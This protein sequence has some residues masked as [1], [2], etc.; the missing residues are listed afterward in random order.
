MGFAIVTVFGIFTYASAFV[1]W[2]LNLSGII[3][4]IF[5]LVAPA[6]MVIGLFVAFL[7]PTRFPHPHSLDL[8]QSE[9]TR[10]VA[11]MTGDKAQAPE[12]NGN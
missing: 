6:L 12:K 3:I 10:A 8:E 9:D 2:K 7:L 1:L 4:L 11:G 5:L